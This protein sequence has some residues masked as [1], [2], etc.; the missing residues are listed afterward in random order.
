[1][2]TWR[3]RQG[4]ADTNEPGSEDGLG[5]VEAFLLGRSVGYFR[6]RKVPIPAWAWLNAVAHASPETVK[7]MARPAAMP[8]KLDTAGPRAVSSI[9]SA[10]CWH[11]GSDSTAISAL[12]QQL[13]IP[14]ELALMAGRIHVIDARAVANL[15]LVTLR[16][17]RCPPAAVTRAAD[18]Q[19]LPP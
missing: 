18:N 19:D 12:Q 1:M 17:G 14:L 4:R 7:V 3:S 8:P 16:A 10:L 11:A 15:A 9:A 13:L 6:A 2:W 5:D